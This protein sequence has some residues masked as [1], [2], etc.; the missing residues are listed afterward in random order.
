MGSPM[1]RNPVSGG[2]VS[3]S[4]V[5]P[6]Y[7]N[8]PMSGSPMSGPPTSGAGGTRIMPGG[9]PAGPGMAAGLAGHQARGAAG[10]PPPPSNETGTFIGSPGGYQQPG[11]MAPRGPSNAGPSN[12]G[13][14]NNNLVVIGVAAVVLLVLLGIGGIY[15]ATKSDDKTPAQVGD[16]NTSAAPTQS[17]TP[18]KATGK[19]V[20]VS[21]KPNFG[22][23]G[24]FLKRELERKGMVVKI[25]QE[26]TKGALPNAVTKIDPC[27]EAIPQGTTITLT[28]NQGAIDD[29]PGPTNTT[30]ANPGATSAA[31]KASVTCA[32]PKII[33]DGA[34]VGA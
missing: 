18:P 4:P 13:R 11:T 23:T 7:G 22:I 1:G 9:A 30:S 29:D 3:G 17:P 16:S 27:G 14:R 6:G 25:V 8:Q 21:C 2:P 26:P 20:A 34:C 19:P 12:G 10:V 24:D 28:V 31:P 33:L 15:L 32:P 5:S